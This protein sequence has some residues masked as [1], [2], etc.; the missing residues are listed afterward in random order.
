MGTHLPS[1]G[2]THTTEILNREQREMGRSRVEARRWL[3]TDGHSPVLKGSHTD[4]VN[5]L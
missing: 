5:R 4:E 3:R 1:S 2:C